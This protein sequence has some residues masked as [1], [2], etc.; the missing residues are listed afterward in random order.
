[1]RSSWVLW[2]I[3]VLLTSLTRG[4]D[5][6]VFQQGVD[7][8]GGTYDGSLSGTQPDTILDGQGVG[9][10]GL[11]M[12][13]LLHGLLR[14]EDI[15]GSGPNQIPQGSTILSATLTLQVFNGSA[16][17]GKTL[18]TTVHRMLQPWSETDTWN[19]WVDGI[20]ADGS[21]AT[22]ASD[23]S[24][25]GAASGPLVID[26]TSSIAEW[27]RCGSSNYGWVF[28][29]AGS[30]D[31]WLAYDSESATP[32]DRPR[33]SVSFVVPGGVVLGTGKC[34]GQALT[35]IDTPLA[36]D[37]FG[38]SVDLDG[39]LAVVGRCNGDNPLAP[40]DSNA[41][42]YRRDAF[43]VWVGE[44]DL[45]SLCSAIG[46]P[47]AGSQFGYA[48]A[49]SGDRVLVGAPRDDDFGS[50][51]EAGVMFAFRYSA[52]VWVCE[53][54]VSAP[55]PMAGD[56]FGSCIAIDGPVAVV[57]APGTAAGSGAAYVY[58]YDVPTSTW[59]L[60]DTSGALSGRLDPSVAVTPGEAF[61]SAVSIRAD[62]LIAVGAPMRGVG[63]TVP[64]F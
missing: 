32:A 6:L 49:V 27:V 56:L 1:M 34:V 9:C 58:R 53:Q 20:Q 8:Y 47:S 38:W 50:T 29:G 26:V 45:L 19:D 14:F 10:S 3:P 33:L 4:Q 28:I 48:V 15:V 39:D 44:T 18:T 42:L 57:G 30:N 25:L 59:I 43:G 62:E 51:P 24:F 2:I 37:N 7:G 40:N 11:G 55:V 12:T 63:G 21:E 22:I 54:R 61:G 16:P 13:A 64:L 17:R 35:P 41:Y 46:D 31:G 60:D 36:E 23:N 5:T 52:P